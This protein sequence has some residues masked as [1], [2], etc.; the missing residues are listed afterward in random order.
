MELAAPAQFTLRIRIPAWLDS[1]AEIQVNSKSAAIPAERRTF[2]AIRRVWRNLDT[3]QVRLPFSFR[4]E[5]IDDRNPDLVAVMRGPLMLVALDPQLTLDRNSLQSAS[6]RTERT[7][8][9]DSFEMNAAPG[10][11]RFAPFYTVGDQMYS[12]YLRKV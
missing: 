5:P 11:L 12:A 10:K 4:T 3:V 8:P 2:A 7:L 6:P 1:P 9:P